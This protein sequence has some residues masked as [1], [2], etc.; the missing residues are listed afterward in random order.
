MVVGEH[1]WLI[2]KGAGSQ[3]QNM[4]PLTVLTFAY[5][6]WS[7]WKL[8]DVNNW[9][10]KWAHTLQSCALADTT[11]TLAHQATCMMELQPVEHIKDDVPETQE[12]EFPNVWYPYNPIKPD[13]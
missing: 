9:M 11:S 5:R 12:L 3:A 8:R 6:W 2:D 4:R 13:I 10:M 1:G 7:A